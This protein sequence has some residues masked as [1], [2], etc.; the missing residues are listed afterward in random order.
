MPRAPLGL[1]ARAHGYAVLV[2][3]VFLV[4]LPLAARSVDPALGLRLPEA[5]MYVGA[6]LL[7]CCA[8]LSYGS[9]WLFIT[10]GRGTAFPTDPPKTL[11]VLGP[12]RYLR[13][14]MYVGNLGIVASGALLLRSP[15]MLLY[16]AVLAWLVDRY[17][18]RVE[19]PALEARYG[20]AYR[21]YRDAIPRWLP[22]RRPHPPAVQPRDD[23]G[24]S[25]RAR[26]RRMRTD[27]SPR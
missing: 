2:V 24:L 27:R 13:N 10:R 25:R 5:A 20:D 14:P 3:G 19:E 16:A 8:A 15:G 17:I 12:Y 9:F 1:F 4:G 21:R 11:V 7:P 18:K 6:L 23:A 22:A 26:V